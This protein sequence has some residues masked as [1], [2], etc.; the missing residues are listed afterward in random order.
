MGVPP[1]KLHEKPDSRAPLG[2]AAFSPSGWPFF[3]MGWG[4][5]STLPGWAFRPRNF[6]KNHMGR[7]ILAAAAF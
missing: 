3:P 6:M 1:A 2:F 7:P 4:G 5:F